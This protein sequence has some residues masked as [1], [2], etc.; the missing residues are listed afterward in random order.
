ME[1]CKDILG[2]VRYWNAG[3]TQ[4]WNTGEPKDEEIE[5]FQ[6][7]IKSMFPSLSREGV[8]D[9]LQD[10]HD[11]V[12]RGRKANR[13]RGRELRF[14]INKFDRKLDR[15]GSGKPECYTNVLLTDFAGFPQI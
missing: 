12:L 1:H 2:M 7:D 4:K 6:L 14:A 10:L 9:A 3:I 8:R 13:G 5:L 15:I 11:A